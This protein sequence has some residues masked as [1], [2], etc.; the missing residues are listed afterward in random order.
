M[1]PL[2]LH[3]HMAQK[4]DL[5]P[6]SLPSH[7]GFSLAPKANKPDL[8]YPAPPPYQSAYPDILLRHLF[9]GVEMFRLLYSGSQNLKPKKEELRVKFSKSF[10]LGR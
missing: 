3:P 8:G 9:V 2:C 7:A 4:L 10:D 6:L 1:P 5:G